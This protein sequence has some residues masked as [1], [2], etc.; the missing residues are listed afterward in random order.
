VCSAGAGAVPRS[1]DDQGLLGAKDFPSLV[2]FARDQA[3]QL[4]LPR[5]LRPNNAYDL[6][7][8]IVT[9]SGWLR[10]GTPQFEMKGAFREQLLAIEGGEAVFD[11][12]VHAAEAL[13][14][15]LEAARQAS[16][17]PRHPDVAR[18]DALLRRIGEDV[19]CAL[20]TSAATPRRRRRWPGT[21]RKADYALAFER[22]W[23]EAAGERPPD[24]LATCG[25]Y[26]DVE[27]VTDTPVAGEHVVFRR[28][29]DRIRRAR[30]RIWLENSYFFPPS[31]LLRDLYDAAA[32]GVDVKLILPCQTDLPIMKRAAR[33][34]YVS[35]IEH[36]LQ[37]FEFCPAVLHAKFGLIDDDWA[38]VGTF[39]A[40]IASVRYSNEANLFVYDLAFVARVAALFESDLARCERLTTEGLRARP[41]F[42]RVADILAN[43]AM[44]A[45][46]AVHAPTR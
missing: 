39:N 16:K 37:L 3:A 5:E 33:A 6:L 10:D 23:A 46:E 14:P 32:R 40:N 13:T 24:D 43:N 28:Y 42:E 1:L 9:A 31:G 8:L 38:T 12:V 36:G 4:D 41:L 35:W 34:E 26:P 30:T 15:E 20:G 27:F 11:E 2:R 29:R 21:S 17:L 19:V 44:A 22:R 25:K 45:L 18:A 7:R